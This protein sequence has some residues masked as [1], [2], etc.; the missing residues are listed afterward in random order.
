M[1]SEIKALHAKLRT[2]TIYVTHDQVEAM[3]MADLIVVL[4]DGRIEQQG[5]PRQLFERPENPFVASFMGSPA[6]NLIRGRVDGGRFAPR[7]IDA[8]LPVEVRPG[9]IILG[10]RPHD[11]R[12]AEDGLEVSVEDIE[13]MGAE[14]LVHARLGE[15]EI[16][17][18]FPGYF[19]VAADRKLRL[20]VAAEH[21]HLFDPRTE[22]RI[23]QR[24]DAGGFAS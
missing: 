10:V 11:W 12:L 18:I 24:Q 7:G 20:G 19:D 17:A 23:L 4:R 3:T 6:M 8:S 13:P 2:T 16:R 21:L 5:T 14:T 9:A 15:T 22:A 1:R